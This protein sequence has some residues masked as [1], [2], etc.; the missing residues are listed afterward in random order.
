MVPSALE[1]LAY[2]EGRTLDLHTAS[3]SA[4]DGTRRAEAWLRERQ[5]ARAGEVLIVTGRGR[6][7]V[8]G[9]AVLRPAVETLLSRLRRLGVVQRYRAHGEGA[10]AVQLAP[11]ARL[12]DA[13]RRHRVRYTP[14]PVA[15]GVFAGLS[16]ETRRALRD[17]AERSLDALGASA[18]PRFVEDEMRRQ[19]S[20]LVPGLPAGEDPDLALRRVAR[21]A[22]EHF[23]D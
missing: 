23:E 8:G 16:A 21:E 5:V 20:L 9:I 18:A 13:P 19:V 17:L 7:S 14:P 22:L 2:G 4:A 6:G 11:V 15:D 1:R 12:F 3:P 10:F